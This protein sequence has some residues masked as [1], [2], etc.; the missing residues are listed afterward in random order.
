MNESVTVK[1]ATPVRAL[2]DGPDVTEL[3]LRRPRVKDLRLASDGSSGEIDVMRKLIAS[4]AGVI[5]PLVDQLELEDFLACVKVISSML[6]AGLV[7]LGT[8]DAGVE[9]EGD[10]GKDRARL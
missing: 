2:G 7:S 8:A 5:P 10:E 1:L 3:T 6:P 4:S 9:D